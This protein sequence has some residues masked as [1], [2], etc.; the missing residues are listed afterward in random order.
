MNDLSGGSGTSV[1]IK[2]L[3]R[4]VVAVSCQY[5]FARDGPTILQ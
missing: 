4:F 3:I 5:L 2:C 1:S